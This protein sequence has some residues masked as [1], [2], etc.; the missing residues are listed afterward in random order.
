MKNLH[1]ITFLFLIVGGLN[2]L[3]QGTVG[4]NIGELFGG[5]D[6]LASRI[7][8]ILVGLSAINEAIIHG[9]NCKVCA[10]KEARK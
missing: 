5:Q 7:I 8:Y 10:I 9:R 4:W 6:G 1:T 3:L 2:W